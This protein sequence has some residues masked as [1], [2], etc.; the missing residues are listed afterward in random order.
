MDGF[1]M[2]PLGSVLLPGMLLPLHVFEERYRRLVDDVLER[3]DAEFGVVL[4]E[5]GSEVGGGDERSSVGCVAR[6]LEAQQTDDGRW[7]I[8]AVGTRRI[9]VTRWLE[10]DPY[11]RADTEDWPDPPVS[12][13][14]AATER[15]RGLEVSVRRVGAL[16][17]ELG[18]DGLPTD[19]TFSEDPEMWAYQLAMMSPLGPMDRQ[20][21]LAAADIGMRM[22][23]LEGFIGEQDE[24]IR[25]RLAFGD[26]DPDDPTG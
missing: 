15:L 21:V 14:Q 16:A 2:F 7:G 20:R 11:P 3:D 8:V 22:D 26:I 13:P 19:L 10:E 1:A 12:D 24:L 18:A 6:I 4:I 9:R 5:R 25:A 23:L 17:S